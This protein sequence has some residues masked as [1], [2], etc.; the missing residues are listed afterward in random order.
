MDAIAHREDLDGQAFHLAAPRMTKAGAALNEFA[1]AAHAPQL[2]V[3]V[4]GELLD[5]L[6]KG[7]FSLL[8]QLPQ[9]KDVRRAVLADF[10]IPDEIVGHMGFDV[11]VRHPRHRAG[12]GGHRHRGPAARGLRRPDLGLLGAQPRSGPLQGS[13]ARGRRQRAHDRHHRRLQRHREVGGAEARQGGRDP[14]ARRARRGE[15]A[16]DEGRDRGGRRDGVRLHRRS[17]R[18]GGDRR[19]RQAHPRRPRAGRHDRQTTPGARSGARS[20]GPRPLPRLR[21]HDQLGTYFGAI[22]LVMGLIRTWPSASSATSWLRQLDRRPDGCR[23]LQRVRRLEV[24]ARP[25]T[26]VV[27]SELSAAT[28]RSRR[29]TCRRCRTPMIARS[30]STTRSRRS[31]PTRRA[32]SSAT[33]SARS[34]SRSTRAWA[35][36]ARSLDALALKAVD[37]ILHTAYKVFPDPSRSKGTEDPDEKASMEQIAMANL[38]KG[39]HW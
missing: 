16:R 19:P 5:A 2:A 38:M 36:S 34:P 14:A 21:A 11:L 29:S 17:L 24:R 12:A 13:L 39:V 27:S 35:R 28:S 25:W 1:K 37:Q 8:L 18:H 4:D 7:V 15:A 3:R 23:R 6:P 10:G 30:R 32:T 22:R 20:R 26:R 33:R 31:R 9:L